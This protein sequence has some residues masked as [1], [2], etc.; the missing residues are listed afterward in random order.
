MRLALSSKDRAL[1]IARRL[2]W[3]LLVLGLASQVLPPLRGAAASQP[4]P[5]NGKGAPRPADAIAPSRPTRGLCSDRDIPALAG[6]VRNW[7]G[8]PK[9]TCFVNTIHRGVPAQV[10]VHEV[11]TSRRVLVCLHGLFAE[12][13]DWRYI[14]AAL[15]GD[16]QLWLID[17][18]GCGD[19]DA[20]APGQLGAG[21]YGPLALADRVLQALEARLAARPDVHRFMLAGHSF[22]G[23][24]VLRM[25]ADEGLR[26]CHAGVLDAVDGLVLLAPCDVV[27][28]QATESQY[29]VLALNGC[30]VTLGSLTGLLQRGLRRS[31]ASDFCDP[32]LA[33]RELQDE[34]LRLLKHGRKRN[35][36]R[37]MLRD[38]VPWRLFGKTPDWVAI[39]PLERDY[40][41][42]LVPCLIVWGEQ[43]LTLPVAMGYKMKDQIPDARMV[44]LAQTRHL[45]PLER[46]VQCAQ[47]VRQFDRQLREGGLSV[48]HSVQTLR[49]DGEDQPEAVAMGASGQRPSV[50]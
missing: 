23:M 29:T 50:Q 10:A 36:T 31:L 15:S 42:I 12:G 48:A 26:Q 44:V 30:K 28:T 6:L 19:S 13:T 21:G 3:A 22:G 37:A 11:G 41:N 34:G 40:Q 7:E 35:A 38:A 4:S 20:P 14:A 32:M 46:P 27:V 18:P 24:V 1:G 9:A 16:Y 45:L 25:F 17:L 39:Q 2:L 49:L 43:D 47:L 8:L 5:G 33:S